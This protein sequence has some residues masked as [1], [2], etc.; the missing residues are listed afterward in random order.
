MAGV[1]PARS[2][3]KHGYVT[4]QIRMKTKMQSLKTM[5]TV[6]VVTF[7]L[8]VT[9]CGSKDTTTQQDMQKAA[10]DAGD[11]IKEAADAVKQA[12]EKVAQDVKETS[13]KVAKDAAA[14]AEELAAPVNAKAQ[15]ILN[16]TQKFISEGKLQE[17]LTKWKQL[18]G[19]KL[20][21]E[22]QALADK[23]KAQLDKVGSA[24]AK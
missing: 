2:F 4:I 24:P 1:D 5:F 9:G 11:A 14:K 7:V 8:A 13:Q 20:S 19:E 17:A 10:N 3:S 18:A 21:A 6:A 16:S 23:L 22:Q 15:E 12:G